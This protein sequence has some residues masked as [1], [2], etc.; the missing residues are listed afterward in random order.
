MEMESLT[1]NK[2]IAK[3]AVMSDDVGNEPK[4]RKNSRID[5]EVVKPI[6]IYPK[7]MEQRRLFKEA[8]DRENRKLSPF[9]VYVVSEYLRKQEMAETAEGRL[10]EASKRFIQKTA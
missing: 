9:I 8:A 10:A 3:V 1:Q 7:T 4:R 2:Q 6:M 5:D